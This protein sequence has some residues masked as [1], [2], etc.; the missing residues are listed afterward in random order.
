MTFIDPQ[1]VSIRRSFDIV[2]ARSIIL[3]HIVE[4]APHGVV[5]SRFHHYQF[6]ILYLMP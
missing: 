3:V 1:L 5:F 6:P 2:P 4:Y